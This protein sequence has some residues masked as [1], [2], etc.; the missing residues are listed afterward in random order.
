[1]SKSNIKKLIVILIVL[2][3]VISFFMSFVDKTSLIYDDTIDKERWNLSQNLS[4]MEISQ[5]FN[6][7]KSS[8]KGAKIKLNVSNY[9]KGGRL[10][11][12]LFSKDNKVIAKG[13]IDISKIDNDDFNEIVFDKEAKLNIDEE[14]KILFKAKLN[15]PKTKIFY[16]ISPDGLSHNIGSV[17][18]NGALFCELINEQF[19]VFAFVAFLILFMFLDVVIIYF[20]VKYTNN[21]SRKRKRRTAR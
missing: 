20:T 5:R 8:C 16:Y 3:I 4:E 18:L 12:E 2:T 17:K 11:C 21:L 6:S 19:S 13:S 7:T 10:R 14:Y 1:M 9:K 15:S